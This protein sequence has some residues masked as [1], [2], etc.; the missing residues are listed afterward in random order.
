[1]HMRKAFGLIIFTIIGFSSYSQ[2]TITGNITDT[3]GQPVPFASISE[4]GTKNGA[5]SDA[6]G[7]FSIKLNPDAQL[8]VSAIGFETQTVAASNASVITLAR[9][10]AEDLPE[11]VIIGLGLTTR[12]DR[13][14]SS[15]STVKGSAITQSG[16]TS[17]LNGIASKASGVFVSRSGGDP[18]AGTYIQIRGQS[19]ITGNLQ[20]LFIIDGVPVS[21]S[22]LGQ[23]IDGVAQQSRMN[24]L[25]AED[26]ES[27]EVLKGAAAAALY[28]TRAANG[29]V[30]ITTKKGRN[31]KKINISLTNTYSVDKLNRSVPLQRSYGQGAD[32]IYGYGSNGDNRSWGDKISERA[33]GEDVFNT[34]GAYAILAGGSKRYLVSSGTE[35]EPHGGKRSQTTYDHAKDLFENG[36]FL[37]N[38]LALSGGDEKGVFY[39][40][41]SN[42]KQE[43]TLR[44]GSDYDRKTFR[45]NAD[46]KF[47]ILKIG[48]TFNYIHSSSDR[49][50]QGSNISGIFLGGLR[51]APD[52]D[53]TFF[54]GTYVDETG[55]QSPNR[56]ISYRNPI[57]ART[58]SGYDN[59]FWI[60]NRIKNTSTLNRITGS[61]EGTLTP[62]SW[63]TIVERAGIDNYTD[64]QRENFPSIS[65]AFPGG[66]LTM[67]T[68]AETQFNN[69]LFARGTFELNDK[70][71]FSVLAGWNFNHRFFD[72]VG[73]T[74]RNFIN[75]D[76]LN[77]RFDFGNSP[78]DA[79]F[80][81]N[82]ES[83]I[84]TTAGYG[85]VSFGLFKQ[86]FVDFTGRAEAA[87]TFN[88]TFFYPSASVG[89]QFSEFLKLKDSRT[90][91]F[92]KIRAS[93]GEVGVQP[94]PYL[95]STYYNPLVIT[96]S[97]GS[98]LD[99]SSA[100]YNGGGYGRS[101]IKGNP[102]LEPERKSEF[103]IGTDLRFINNRLTL[104][105][106]YYK[107]KTKG[108]IFSVQVPSTTG[109]LN[110]NDNAAELENKGVELDL[111]Y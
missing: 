29:V 32:G 97:F 89:W 75:E 96:E 105:A 67:Q 83:Q 45:L 55:V 34:D 54:E 21:N 9:K 2:S 95:L 19:T 44:A 107:N 106:T 12:K 18:G 53:N 24:D 86:L 33:G 25:N 98:G 43:G 7:N 65:S 68:I 60:I 90:L 27:M 51:T 81:F 48:G 35:T 82:A 57:G 71:N 8:K 78:G 84:R 63:L 52:F 85:Q 104:S 76:I 74:V 103:E 31:S 100:T 70:I 72:N 37:D 93:Y 94:E 42:L 4:V 28:G 66:Q 47:G 111:D 59:P 6:T 88:S 3:S 80:P 13:L 61:F 101:S 92:G 38:T 110:T 79:R 91:S 108:A 50:Q 22:T 64:K 99:A 109:F 46:R 15:Q 23:V 87:S 1:M 73:G 30:L 41:F 39:T 77:P 102:D 36:F 20:P 5:T 58:N 14:T 11:V 40:S 69:D 62:T 49:A 56:Q 17:V 10:I 26:V 16:E